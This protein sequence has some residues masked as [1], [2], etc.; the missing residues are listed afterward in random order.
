MKF[1][2]GWEMFRHVIPVM[3]AGIKMEFVGDMAGVEEIVARF[4]A[5]VEAVIVFRTAIE[6]YFQ[7]SRARHLLED[8]GGIVFLPVSSVGRRAE[9]AAENAVEN[10]SLIIR[11]ANSGKRRQKCGA[12]RAHRTK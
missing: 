2:R 8:G 9:G 4:R 3:A 1:Q 11:T 10:S 5:R 6:I 7:F 12:V